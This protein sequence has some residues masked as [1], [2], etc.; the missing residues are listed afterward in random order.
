ERVRA[1]DQLE[2]LA[3]PAAR[4]PI[5]VVAPDGSPPAF[6][7]IT[8][9]PGGDWRR[10]DIQ[11]LWSA[12]HPEIRVDPGTYEVRASDD[13]EEFQRSSS[14]A[15]ELVAGV[16]PEPLRLELKRRRVLL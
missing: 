16:A 6:A 8:L 10:S 5:E 12:D 3:R 2:W 4:L 14:I 7:L 9:D 15:V 13:Y 1:G 11:K